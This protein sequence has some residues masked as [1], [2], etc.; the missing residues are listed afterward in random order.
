MQQKSSLS[1]QPVIGAAL[2]KIDNDYLAYRTRRTLSPKLNL[3]E[4][5]NGIH[6]TSDGKEK[7][8]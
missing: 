4:K 2:E 3:T 7:T 8:L 5:A 6:S 1:E